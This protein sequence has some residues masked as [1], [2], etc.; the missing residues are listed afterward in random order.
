M[1]N[2][3]DLL[4][5]LNKVKPDRPNHWMA[6]CPSHNDNERSLSITALPDKILVNCMA[7]CPIKSVLASLKLEPRNLFLNDHRQMPSSMP[8]EIAVAYDY[9]NENGQIIFQVVTFKPK[10]NILPGLVFGGR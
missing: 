6:L 7:G 8:K 3:N 10:S 1:K 9:H 4:K 5:L 2:V